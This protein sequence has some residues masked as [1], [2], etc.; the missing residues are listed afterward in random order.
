M[1]DLID[2]TVLFILTHARADNQITLKT[3]QDYGYRG[4]VL[5]VVDDNDPEL[6][7][8]ISKYGDMVKIFN[9]DEI[10]EN[11]GIDMGD[12]FN[13]YLNCVIPR[14]YCFELA[15]E[16]G[17]R[18]FCELDDDYMYFSY[19][20]EDTG[21]C[22]FVNDLPCFTEIVNSMVN[23]LENSGADGVAFAQTGD[24]L[25][26]LNSAVFKQKIIRKL[27]NTIF[28]KTDNPVQFKGSQNDD[29][30]LYVRG[31]AMGKVFLTPHEIAIGQTETQQ[32]TGGL[33]ELYGNNTYVKSFYS[34]MYSPAN[35]KIGVF[36]GKHPRIHHKVISNNT[37]PKIL[38]E[39]YKKGA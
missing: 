1:K 19:R 14:N 28:F 15:K 25:A 9:K 38:H 26:G 12:N 32:T 13:N 24:Y 30:T 4:T 31:A 17:Y 5:L 23:F 16:L 39:K 7:E 27:M 35:V 33:T 22:R 10:R 8:Y 21:S 11:M 20:Y 34:V 18:Y 2:E 29:V 3:L 37:Y 36:P 6:E